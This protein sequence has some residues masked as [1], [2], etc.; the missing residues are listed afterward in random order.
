MENIERL[1]EQ[2]RN[3]PDSKLFLPLAEEY[4]KINMPEEAV[5]VLKNGI[6]R[7]PDYMSAHVALGKIYMEKN[8][9]EEAIIEFETVVDAIPDN[10]F[11]QKKLLDLYRAIGLTEKAR[12]A[13]E[14]VLALHPDDE[15]AQAA[16]KSFSPVYDATEG[17]VQ[18]GG[19][20]EG[21]EKEIKK[22]DEL[23]IEEK[24]Y[25]AVTEYNQ[26]LEKHQDNRHVLQR[27]AELKHYAKL[28]NKDGPPIT[29]KLDRFLDG[30]QQ[31]E[32]GLKRE[33]NPWES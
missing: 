10:F 18:S 2:I 7:N 27:L 22:I 16:L 17:A 33:T 24:L 32:E 26:L 20:E 15:E 21:V 23:I 1:K 30:V 28:I 4:R 8:L 25:K 11:A 9:F 3:D 12:D 5:E 14:R 19:V 29:D 13:S 31:R 6:E